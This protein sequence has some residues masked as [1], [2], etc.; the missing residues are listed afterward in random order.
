MVGDVG[1]EQ[2]QSL[3][4]VGH[5]IERARNLAGAWKGAGNKGKSGKRLVEPLRVANQSQRGGLI[6]G[7]RTEMT[8]NDRSDT[9][10]RF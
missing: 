6:Q 7:G 5:A 8:N 3:V 4:A 2:I 9:P 1:P 10:I